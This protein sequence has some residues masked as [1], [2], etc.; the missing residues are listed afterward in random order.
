MGTIN[1]KAL[2]K[3]FSRKGFRVN[4]KI[5]ELFINLIEKKLKTDTEKITR[6]AR[7]S[8]RKTIRKEDFEEKGY[9]G[10][11]LS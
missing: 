10:E 2:K 9:L 5:L 1:K 3:E 8:G 11:L 4:S 7:L 6:N